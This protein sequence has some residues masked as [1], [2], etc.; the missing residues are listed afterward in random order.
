MAGPRFEIVKIAQRRSTFMSDYDAIVIG[1]GSPG[2]HCAGALA[3]GGLRRRA[4]RARSRRRRMF[5][6]GVHPVEDIAPPGRGRCIRP[7]RRGRMLAGGR[8]RQ[9]C[10]GAM[11]W[12]PTIPMPG[13]R[14]G[15]LSKGIDL[16]RGTGNASR[17]RRGR[18]GRRAPHRQPTSC[19]ATG[20][21]A[22]MP[23][24]PGLR[25]LARRVWSSRDVT[26]HEGRSAS[27]C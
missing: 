15:S 22:V 9:R 17:A 3:E 2:E 11:S 7:G 18:R 1:G 25:D 20:S 24:V 13:N 8:G 12:F 21:D 10:L 4:G 16:I 6:L 14:P 23:P 19:I 5:V 27:A 26:S